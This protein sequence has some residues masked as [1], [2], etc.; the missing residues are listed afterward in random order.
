MIAQFPPSNST[1]LYTVALHTIIKWEGKRNLTSK[2]ID[3]KT[4][5]HHNNMAYIDLIRITT[6]LNDSSIPTL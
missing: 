2:T 1:I 3:T 5:L 6:I 4:S